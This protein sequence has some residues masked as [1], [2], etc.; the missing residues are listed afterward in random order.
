MDARV[1]IRRR[2]SATSREHAQVQAAVPDSDD[3]IRVVD[4]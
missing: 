1:E 3:E 2:D 4:G